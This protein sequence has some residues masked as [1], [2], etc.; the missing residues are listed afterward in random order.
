M[1]AGPGIFSGVYAAFAKGDAAVPG[2]PWYLACGMLIV[3][4]IV[5]RAIMPQPKAAAATPV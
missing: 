5:A 3:S 1:L 2:A 4:M